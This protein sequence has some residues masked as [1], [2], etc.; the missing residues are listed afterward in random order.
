MS[1]SQTADSRALLS[2]GKCFKQL[3]SSFAHSA[4]IMMA[5]DFVRES[6]S[7]T[8]GSSESGFET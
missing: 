3:T 2:S 8:D 5:R 7:S 1:H 4:V 6:K